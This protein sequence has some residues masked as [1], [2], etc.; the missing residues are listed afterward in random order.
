MRIIAA[1]LAFAPAFAAIPA[2]ALAQVNYA[3]SLPDGRTITLPQ[4]LAGCEQTRQDDQPGRGLLLR[5][6]C[7]SPE[8]GWVQVTAVSIPLEGTPRAA[9]EG[10]AQRWWPQF[11]G[12]PAE[13]KANALSI[14]SKTLMGGAKADFHCLHRDNIEAL[15]GDAACILDTPTMQVIIEAQSSMASTADDAI[16][17]LLA[18]T[19]LR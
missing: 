3:R 6:T 2:P 8:A 9:L 18:A 12:W 5:F 17:A 13:Q 7:T 4:T 11:A 19:L 1:L 15:N 14:Q 16:D 10:Q